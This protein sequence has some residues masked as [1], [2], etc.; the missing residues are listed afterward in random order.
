MIGYALLNCVRHYSR[1]KMTSATA[2]T[3]EDPE[4][5]LA[6]LAD[7]R[8]HPAEQAAAV[9]ALL[10][11]LNAFHRHLVRRVA[12]EECTFADVARELRRHPDNIRVHYRRAIDILRAPDPLRLH[13][14][15]VGAVGAVGVV[16]DQ[17]VAGGDR[18]R[19]GGGAADPRPDRDGPVHRSDGS[20]GC[21]GGFIRWPTT[22][23][24]AGGSRG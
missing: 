17:G 11:P 15:Q 22:P 21:R 18:D 2:V 5:L 13:R 19:H 1:H 24:S 10:A 23:T 4:F 8:R 20:C 3:S 16:L 12:I 6:H 7:T 14:R 9:D